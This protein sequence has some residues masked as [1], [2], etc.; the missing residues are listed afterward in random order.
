MILKTEKL[1]EVEVEMPTGSR[2]IWKTE[3]LHEVEVKMLL[4]GLLEENP[5][6]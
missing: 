4:L 5:S 6:P 3:K 1:H 2:M